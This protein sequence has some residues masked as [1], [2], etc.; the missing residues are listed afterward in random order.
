MINLL[1]GR[2]LLTVPS[3]CWELITMLA[4]GPTQVT[5][6]KAGVGR[7][8]AKRTKL[9]NERCE[10]AASASSAAD[11]LQ[12]VLKVL[13]QVDTCATVPP[14]STTYYKSGIHG[15]RLFHQNSS[16]CTRAHRFSYSDRFCW[17]SIIDL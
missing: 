13:P 17:L 15:P 16:R 6:V 10:V 11:V 3:R 8:F 7:N 1:F 5:R 2:E 14:K 9:T 12:E 4:M